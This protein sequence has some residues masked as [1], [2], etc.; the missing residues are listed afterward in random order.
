MHSPP[1]QIV[2]AHQ[3]LSKD[4]AELVE[5]YK[6]ASKYASTVLDVDYNKWV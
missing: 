5:A 4:M 2:L 6:L 1:P 3:V